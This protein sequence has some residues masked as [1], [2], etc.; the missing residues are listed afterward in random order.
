MS[1]SLWT[2]QHNNTFQIQENFRKMPRTK[3]KPTQ[4]KQSEE[5]KEEDVIYL[6]SSSEEEEK[7]EVAFIE[8]KN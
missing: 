2:E 1:V 5:E 8:S 3:S 7:Q 4:N 6:V